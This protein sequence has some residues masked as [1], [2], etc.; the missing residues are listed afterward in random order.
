MSEFTDD[1]S[2]NEIY[3]PKAIGLLD[4]AA[5]IETD[6]RLRLVVPDRTLTTPLHGDWLLKVSGERVWQ[7][8]DDDYGKQ[9]SFNP[10][11][12]RWAAHVYPFEPIDSKTRMPVFRDQERL[13]LTVSLNKTESSVEP[14]PIE[15]LVDTDYGR[16]IGVP[17]LGTYHGSA[18]TEFN[19]TYWYHVGQK[20]N[21]QVIELTDADPSIPPI[22]VQVM[23]RMAAGMSYHEAMK[24]DG[25][26][27]P[28][29]QANPHSEREWETWGGHGFGTFYVP[30]VD[31]YGQPPACLVRLPCF[32]IGPTNTDEVS[33][34]FEHTGASS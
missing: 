15:L 20:N 25:Y 30:A 26:Q 22:S 19:F 13:E 24:D 16:F 28:R 34:A 2:G 11:G 32:E 6:E 5:L 7:K 23:A 18:N 27:S 10:L 1:Q 8:E 31:L 21:M 3:L 14:Y 4:G 12:L 17:D 9:H 33:G 29:P